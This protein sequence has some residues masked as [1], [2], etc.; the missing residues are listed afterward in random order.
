[1]NKGFWTGFEK[2]GGGYGGYERG[3][4]GGFVL[5]S[6]D[7]GMGPDEIG[8]EMKKNHKNGISTGYAVDGKETKYDPSR[9]KEHLDDMR[10]NW[11]KSRISLLAEHPVTDPAEI[12]EARAIVEK[13]EKRRRFF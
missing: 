2:R 6:A 9:H 13:R 12:E 3:K 4:D 1:M 10:R 5:S 7:W 11:A 8:S